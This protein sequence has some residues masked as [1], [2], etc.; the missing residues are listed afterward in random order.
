MDTRSLSERGTVDTTLPHQASVRPP[1]SP[2]RPPH[3][4]GRAAS[5]RRRLDRITPGDGRGRTLIAGRY[6]LGREIG[7]G[8]MGAVWLARDE[9]LGRDVAVKRIGMAPGGGSPDLDRAER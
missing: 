9:V 4:D 3:E 8:G 5:G 7:R 2:S 1:G 6:T